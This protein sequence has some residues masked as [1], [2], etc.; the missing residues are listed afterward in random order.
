MKFIKHFSFI[1]NEAIFNIL[2]KNNCDDKMLAVVYYCG[3][4]FLGSCTKALSSTTSSPPSQPEVP[5]LQNIFLF[6]SRQ[7][8]ISWSVFIPVKGSFTC[9]S[10]FA[11]SLQVY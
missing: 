10:N 7:A 3:P 6:R 8:E 5:I 2:L 4:V 1:L 11:L 9:K